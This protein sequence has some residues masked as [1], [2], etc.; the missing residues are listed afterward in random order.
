MLKYYLAADLSQ[1]IAAILRKENVDV[2]S[3]NEAGTTS[4]SDE[5]HLE[6]AAAA[7]RCLVTRNRDDFMELT[8][9]FF[10][11]VRP[12]AGILIIPYS[13]PPDRFSWIANSLLTYARAHPEG[14]PSYTFDFLFP[15]P[16]STRKKRKK[17]A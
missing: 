9:H 4:L 2:V 6:R 15:P 12:H 3:S 1:K 16:V 14:V 8:I 17:H 5:E 11:D 7:G 10:R 13:Y